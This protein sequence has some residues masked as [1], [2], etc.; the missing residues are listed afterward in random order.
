MNFTCNFSIADRI[1]ENPK[2]FYALRKKRVAQE[3]VCPLKDSGGNLCL[4]Q[5]KVGEQLNEYFASVSTK[6]TDVVIGELRMQKVD[7]LIV[8]LQ[9]GSGPFSTSSIH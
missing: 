5:D 4:Q 9:C 1:K 6:E 2:A 3:R 7:I 8:S